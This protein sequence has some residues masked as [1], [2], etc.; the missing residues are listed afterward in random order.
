M[1]ERFATGEIAMRAN[2]DV[3]ELGG[4]EDM[5]RLLGSSPQMVE[6]RHLIRRLARQRR[7][8]LYFRRVGYR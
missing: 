2:E 7:A 5:P 1:K 6:V 8:R 3:P 4:E